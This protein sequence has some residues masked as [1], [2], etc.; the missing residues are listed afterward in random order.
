MWKLVKF[1]PIAVGL[2][3]ATVPSRASTISSD[4]AALVMMLDWVLFAGMAA[5]IVQM[6]GVAAYRLIGGLEWW[7]ALWTGSVASLAGGMAF[8]LTFIDAR[9]GAWSRHWLTGLVVLLV[10]ELPLLAAMNRGTQPWRRL[11]PTAALAITALYTALMLLAHTA[12]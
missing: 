9:P 2:V 12:A 1:T 3:G 4:A 5:V 11:L 10:V 7:R 8:S 6:P